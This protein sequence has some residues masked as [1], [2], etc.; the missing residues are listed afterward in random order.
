MVKEDFYVCAL[1][2][3]DLVFLSDRILILFILFLPSPKS[4]L[5]NEKKM[6]TLSKFKYSLWEDIKRVIDLAETNREIILAD[7]PWALHNR[8]RLLE[9][10]GQYLIILD[11]DKF[12]SCSM[13]SS[14]RTQVYSEFLRFGRSKVYPKMVQNE[15][16]TLCLIAY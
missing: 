13:S 10:P 16:K 7:L 9:K 11:K 1:S 8:I 3:S 15:K 5:K 14:I 6:E 2:Y 12:R 4:E